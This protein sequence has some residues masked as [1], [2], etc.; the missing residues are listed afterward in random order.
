M[1]R[2]RAIPSTRGM[3][4]AE[5]AAHWLVLHDAGTLSASEEA[6]FAAWHDDPSHADAYR[7]AGSAMAI[8][9]ADAGSDP[10]LR[11]LRQAALEAAPAPRWHYYAIAASLLVAISLSAA[12]LFLL[13]PDGMV[14]NGPGARSSTVIAATATPGSSEAVAGSTEYSTGIGERRVVRLADGTSVTLNTHSKL[15]VAFTANRR[16]VRLARGQALFEVAHDRS[17]PFIVEA[18]DRQITALGTVF[19][20]RVD[21]GRV[22]VVL[23]QGRVVVDRQPDMMGADEPASMPPAILKPGQQFSAELGAPQRVEAVDVERQLLWR[24]GFVEF[25]DETLAHAVAEINRYSKHPIT[26]SND[27]VAALHV[28]GLYRTGSPEQFIDA[29]QG[30]LPVTAKP[31]PQGNIEISLT[32]PQ[33]R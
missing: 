19:E 13:R 1:M 15:T 22:N 30:L 12:T 9:G 10:N 20:V 5:A 3:S 31:T 18:A 32:P 17:R 26:L 25:D 23:F 24:S 28:S 33:G 14:G 21:V 16:I 11:A 6:E 4:S 8:F 2:L 7:R 27:G 29:L